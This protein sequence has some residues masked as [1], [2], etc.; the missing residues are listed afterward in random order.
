M[1][2]T[3]LLRHKVEPTGTISPFAGTVAPEGWLLLHNQ[4][5]QI[6]D[7][8]K[9]FA[10]IGTQYGGNG[11]T[12]FRLPDYRGRTAVGKDNMGGVAANRITSTK[13]GINGN[14]LG[15]FGGSQTHTITINQMPLHGHPYITSSDTKGNSTGGL[16]AGNERF[17]GTAPA[18]TGTP[19]T[20]QTQSIGGTGGGQT[21]QNTQPS[22]ICNYIIKVV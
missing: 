10:I 15:A 7:Y 22:I 20:N 18:Y 6:A 4:T 14:V 12:T 1:P 3:T 9:L 19:T 2:R 5:L 11:T 13:S 16:M 21:H 17:I 8:P